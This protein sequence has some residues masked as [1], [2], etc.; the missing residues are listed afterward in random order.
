MTERPTKKGLETSELWL[1]LGAG[2]GVY[3][4]GSAILAIVT[5]PAPLTMAQAVCAVAVSVCALGLALVA[6]AYCLSRA[7]SKRRA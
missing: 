4:L 1:G 2:Y 5:S 3:E 7:W 6:C